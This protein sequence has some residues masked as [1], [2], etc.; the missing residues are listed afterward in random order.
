MLLSLSLLLALRDPHVRFHLIPPSDRTQTLIRTSFVL[1]RS[2]A[3]YYVICVYISP[4]TSSFTDVAVYP[5]KTIEEE[6]ERLR[7][8][9]RSIVPDL[10]T[11]DDE[12]KI[13]DFIV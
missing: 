12:K 2:T 10:D 13:A 5:P 8:H 4:P 3:I 9:S 6:Q 7:L 1:H 11:P